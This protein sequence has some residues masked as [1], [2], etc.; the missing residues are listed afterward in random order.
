MFYYAFN[1]EEFI[2]EKYMPKGFARE[3]IFGMQLKEF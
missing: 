1:I 2:M 3:Q